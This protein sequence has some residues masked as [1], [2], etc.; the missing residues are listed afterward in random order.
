M[1]PT[2]A[3]HRI[4][5][6]FRSTATRTPQGGGLHNPPTGDRATTR[7]MAKAAPRCGPNSSPG[8]ACPLPRR[9]P[10]SGAAGGPAPHA[11]GMPGRGQA[12]EHQ[13][14]AAIGTN[15]LKPPLRNFHAVSGEISLFTFFLVTGGAATSVSSGKSPR[16]LLLP[17]NQVHF[18][19]VLIPRLSTLVTVIVG[20]PDFNFTRSPT[21]NVIVRGSLTGDKRS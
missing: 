7:V 17:A 10:T 13:V 19:I 5:P 11:S 2:V 18:T 4:L 16:S 20:P 12:G 9:V 3:C 14:H 15:C 6:A 1:V 21:L 8:A